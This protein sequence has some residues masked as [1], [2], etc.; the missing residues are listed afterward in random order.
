MK[1]YKVEIASLSYDWGRFE[2]WRLLGYYTTKAKAEQ[3][4]KE[5]YENR[6]PID[7]GKAQITE[8]EVEE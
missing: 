4:A 1:I 2:G 5:A 3:V 6:C 8:I 7:T